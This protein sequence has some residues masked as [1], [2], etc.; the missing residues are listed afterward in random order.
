MKTLYVLVLLLIDPFANLN[1]IATINRIKEAAEAAYQAN[2]YEQAAKHYT[3]LV[4]SLQVEDE[5]VRLNLAHALLLAGDTLRA[6]QN[7]SRLTASDNHN[8]KSVAYQQMGVVASSQKKYEEAL[9]IFKESLK[10]DP[11]N[12]GAR[13]DYELVKKLLKQQEEQE[14]QSEEQQDSSE[15]EQNEQQQQQNEQQQGEEEQEQQDQSG[16]ENQNGEQQ[17]GEPSEEQ[18]GEQSE[19]QS[20]ETSEEPGDDSEEGEGNQEQPMSPSVSDKL[21]EMNISEEKARMILEAMRNNE[22]QYIQQNRRKPQKPRDRTKP[23][24]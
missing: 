22:M 3:R 15:G 2:N 10:A 4:D 23:D 8:L 7:Y 13:Y 17:E 19:A 9:T 5:A 24:W 14:Q 21:K 11:G 16:E 20:E 18:K 1:D 6:Q 12:E